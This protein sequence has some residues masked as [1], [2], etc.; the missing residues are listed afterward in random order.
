MVYT[1]PA[2]VRD[3]QPEV[4]GSVRTTDMSREGTVTL[5]E[6]VKRK[7]STSFL[8]HYAQIAFEPPAESTP[9]PGIY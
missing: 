2:W 7:G 8:A 6:L 5:S 4:P 9:A 3:Q 1:P